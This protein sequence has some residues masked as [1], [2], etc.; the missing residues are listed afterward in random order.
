MLMNLFST[1][2]LAALLGDSNLTEV[3]IPQWL[4]FIADS[5]AYTQ[6]I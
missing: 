5:E 1:L 6:V 2:S 3:T 4:S